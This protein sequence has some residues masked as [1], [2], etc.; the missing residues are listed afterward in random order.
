[1]LISIL[2]FIQ[3][4]FA[5]Q[6]NLDSGIKK[7]ELDT[8]KSTDDSKNDLTKAEKME[9]TNATLMD[10]KWLLR[11]IPLK[12]IQTDV[13]DSSNAPDQKSILLKILPSSNPKSSTKNKTEV[14]KLIDNAN[15]EWQA[16]ASSPFLKY[17]P[18]AFRI[19]DLNPRSPKTGS[20]S[21]HQQESSNPQSMSSIKTTLMGFDQ[22]VCGV[23]RKLELLISADPFIEFKLKEAYLI[24][25]H[26]LNILDNKAIA[27]LFH[28]FIQ[29]K[30]LK[31]LFELHL[32]AY[33]VNFKKCHCENEIKS[34]KTQIE[35]EAMDNKKS[36][37]MVKE[38]LDIVDSKIR[39]QLSNDKDPILELRLLEISAFFNN[40][41]T[42]FELCVQKFQIEFYSGSEMVLK[43]IPS[44]VPQFLVK[45]YCNETN[46]SPLFD[47]YHFRLLIFQ[48]NVKTDLIKLAEITNT[49]EYDLVPSL[50]SLF[51]TEKGLTDSYLKS[52]AVFW[53][54]SYNKMQCVSI[55]KAFED[56]L[57]TA[58]TKNT[59]SSPNSKS[60]FSGVLIDA[61]K[62]NQTE[63]SPILPG[64]VF[65]KTDKDKSQAPKHRTRNLSFSPRNSMEGSHET[66]REKSHPANSPE[67]NIFENSE[68]ESPEITNSDSAEEH[69]PPIFE[70]FEPKTTDESVKKLG[71]AFLPET[72]NEQPPQFDSKEYELV[73]EQT[74][75]P[76]LNIKND[77]TSDPWFL[78]GTLNICCDLPKSH[79]VAL[80]VDNNIFI[81][82]SKKKLEQS[83]NIT[84]SNS[85][86]LSEPELFL[87]AQSI[88]VY[89]Q[90]LLRITP[91]PL[92]YMHTPIFSYKAKSYIIRNLAAKFLS[93]IT[94]FQNFQCEF[95]KFGSEKIILRGKSVLFD[96]CN[97]TEKFLL[98][99]RIDNLII[100]QSEGAPIY[101]DEMFL[102]LH[103]FQLQYYYGVIHLH[104]MVCDIDPGPSVSRLY[105]I[106]MREGIAIF[107]GYI[108]SG[109]ISWP[110]SVTQIIFDNCTLNELTIHDYPNKQLETRNST[111]S[112]HH[113][114]KGTIYLKNKF[115]ELLIDTKKK[116]KS[117]DRLPSNPPQ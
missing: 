6:A 29:R 37:L 43:G 39:K 92:N 8:S 7:S 27:K 9:S 64:N 10:Q 16:A 28:T 3:V 112:V 114:Q 2:S 111:G 110:E 63:Y 98:S 21:E 35:A 1:M 56:I 103:S 51:S 76:V 101:I 33:S 66:A 24:L 46:I 89:F 22:V 100:K 4:Y 73:Y 95:V 102:Y 90:N 107:Q 5:A 58:Y 57:N 87:Q 99:G 106:N 77:T 97:G 69:Y 91:S 18:N 14:E 17:D 60:E 47:F 79:L 105:C 93:P 67:G 45:M 68:S 116:N 42:F 13:S 49:F 117:K 74:S 65:P 36:L 62:R 81:A 94:G 71:K 52:L 82:K 75:K 31:E 55:I 15:I 72:L 115:K 23:N 32:F 53:A 30:S 88:F 108:I 70:Y 61:L 54:R 20:S 80:I 26:K 113:T 40:L 38:K 11:F 84:L 34:L 41:T 85:T 44:D 104:E 78:F 19:F 83:S 48:P 96:H 109:T 86:S 25:N 59:R 12:I 50:K